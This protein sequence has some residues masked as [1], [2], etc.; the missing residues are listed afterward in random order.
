MTRPADWFPLA[1]ADPVPGDPDE[2]DRCAKRHAVIGAELVRQAGNLRRFAAADGW[3]GE[4]ARAFTASAG[5]L[6]KL[7][8]AAAHRYDAAARILAGYSPELR[9]AQDLA[10]RALA[11]ARHAQ[12]EMSAHTPSVV[13]TALL[14]TAARVAEVRRQAAYDHSVELL[15]RAQLL[16]RDAVEH[17]DLHSLRAARAIRAAT[18]SDGLADSWWDRFSYAMDRLGGTAS[19]HGPAPGDTGDDRLVVAERV[20]G[21]SRWPWQWLND[22]FFDITTG[23]EAQDHAD[24]IARVAA[25]AGIDPR[26]LMAMVLNESGM[27]Q[28]VPAFKNLDNP[29]C[30]MQRVGI[31]DGASLGMTSL[32]SSVFDATVDRHPDRFGDVT[33]Y[34]LVHDNGLSIKVTA[35][36]LRD[37]QDTLPRGYSGNAG[38]T[39][40]ELTAYGYNAGERRMRATVYAEADLVNAG[41]E[42]VEKFRRNWTTSDEFFCRSEQWTCTQH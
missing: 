25:E 7:V 15:R 22:G 16:L 8:N 42:Y 11:E 28:R 30:A 40:E 19:G 27:R 32:Q 12:A 17:R 29:L 5:D 37:L 13:G 6:A 34:D 10:G 14:T 1:E 39:R 33:W 4:A 20:K 23:Y 2:I 35:W 18:D 24:H 38:Y 3:T 31:R 26:L 21:N 41:R 9:H 36:H